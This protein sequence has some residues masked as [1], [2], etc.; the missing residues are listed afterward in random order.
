MYLYGFMYPLLLAPFINLVTH[1]I[2][3]ASYLDFAFLFLFLCLSFWIFR[4][5]NASFISSLIGT[6]I[7]LNS[8]IFIWKIN[9]HRPDIM[10]LFFALLGLGI[11]LN[12]EPDNIRILLCA[13]S[14]VISFYFKQ[15]MLFSA[16]VAAGYLFLFVSKKKGV[17]FIT[18]LFLMG[19]ISFFVARSIFPLYYEYTIL[20]H[21]N[22]AD[23]STSYMLMQTKLFLQY[24]WILC[25]LYLFYLYKTVSALGFR[26]IKEIRLMPT[27]LDAPF[28]D[29]IS[30]DLFDVGIIISSLILTFSLGKHSGNVYTYYGELLLPFLL[31][32]IIPKIDEL[33]KINLTHN[34]IQLLIL[35]FCV[36]PLRLSY[37]T[38]FEAYKNAF[39]QVYQYADQCNTIYDQTPLIALYKIEH[40]MSP[41][42][43]NG[44]I[45]YAWSVVPNKATI[46]GR[47]SAFSPESVNKNLIDWND[48]IKNNIQNQKFD[49]IFSD[50][51][52]KIDLEEIEN[53]REEGKIENVLGYTVYFFVPNKP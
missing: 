13:L 8:F 11:L 24:Y 26:R 39:S 47:I 12:G 38:N 19:M 22:D 27:N 32:L 6:L 14:C 7:L 30:V 52:N 33:F 10:G 5:R 16:L 2:L 43:N 31:Y 40:G 36:F 50:S 53:Y 44:Q 37:S 18:I 51:I 34:L 15:Y 1:P 23:N 20:H 48:D 46:F 35:F 9:G 4:K 28:I 49:C 3:V 45:E 25:I 42:Y 29:G 17:L 41:V 21:I